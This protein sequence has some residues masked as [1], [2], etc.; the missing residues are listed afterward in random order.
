MSCNFSYVCLITGNVRIVYPICR[1][2]GIP[3]RKDDLPVVTSPSPTQIAPTSPLDHSTTNQVI[4][5]I[6]ITSPSTSRLKTRNNQKVSTGGK[7]SQ[8]PTAFQVLNPCPDPKLP[9]D[10]FASDDS[11]SDVGT[12][13]TEDINMQN[14]L[15]NFTEEPV[16]ATSKDKMLGGINIKVEKPEIAHGTK[17]SKKSSKDNVASFNLSDIKTELQDDFDWNN[18]TLATVN[19]NSNVNRFQT[20]Y[21]TSI[22]YFKSYIL[23]EFMYIIT[24]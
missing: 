6:I 15:Q 12:T 22:F 16:T 13:V 5:N 7:S 4:N 20:R 24:F 17:K 11:V 18:M 2:N 3:S 9:A 8:T 14:L 19:N 10:I 1:S 21:S 23:Y